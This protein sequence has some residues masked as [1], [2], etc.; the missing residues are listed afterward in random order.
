MQTAAG[1]IDPEKRCILNHGNQQEIVGADRT[2]VRG[3]EFIA[4][5]GTRILCLSF[6]CTILAHV[7]TVASPTSREPPSLPALDE[8]LDG[9]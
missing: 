7:S 1:N 2:P 6:P 3:C 5:A 9:R 8:S 4:S